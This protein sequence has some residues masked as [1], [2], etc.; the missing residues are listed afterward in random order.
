M[1]DCV[2]FGLPVDKKLVLVMAGAALPQPY[3]RFRAAM[4]ET[5][6]YLRSF[7]NMHFVFLP[8]KDIA[9]AKHLNSVFE[10][11]KLPNASV[12]DYVDDMAALMRTCDL[13]ILKSGGLTV[14]EC[15]CAELPIDCW[16]S[17]TGRKSPIRSCSPRLARAC[18]RRPSEQIM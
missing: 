2:A 14:T 9:Y 8:G 13:A 16:E 5:L 7:E 6:P 1:Q 11:M 12:L 3:V 17:R 10:G 4:E 15:L 18:T